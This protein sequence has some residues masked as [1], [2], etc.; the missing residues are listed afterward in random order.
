MTQSPN[1]VR[2]TSD[3]SPCKKNHMELAIRLCLIL[4]ILFLGLFMVARISEG[5]TSGNLTP[6]FLFW[7][8]AIFI[9][10]VGW[11]EAADLIRNKGL[12]CCKMGRA[13]TAVSLCLIP[14]AWCL[15]WCAIAPGFIVPFFIHPIGLVV[16]STAAFWQVLGFIFLIPARSMKRSFLVVLFFILMAN[17]VLVLFPLLGPILIPILTVFWQVPK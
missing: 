9:L 5:S 3:L 10:S 7:L 15:T 4:L 17:L 8:I 2:N 6:V 13:M 16:I 11:W 14:W 1:S 12:S